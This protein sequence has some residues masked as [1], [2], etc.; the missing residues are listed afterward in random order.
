MRFPPFAG[1]RAFTLIELLVVIAII[2]VLISLLLPAVQQAREAARRTQ[3]RNNLK[4]I[5]LAMHNHNDTYRIFPMGANPQLYSPL[6]AVL[7]FMD[8]AN[9]QNLYD[10]DKSYDDAD[11]QA[12]LASSLSIYLCPTMV[13]PREV[14]LVSC[15]EIGGP[16]SYGCSMGTTEGSF[17]GPG[18]I[19]DGLFSGYN[20]L[21]TPIAYRFRDIID[22][23]SNTLMCGEF[24]YQ[25]QDLTWTTT[26][27][28]PPPTC[29]DDPAM[30]GQPRWGSH[31]WG[32]GYPY[33]SLGC[34]AGD[35][36]V[37]LAV[38]QTTWRSDHA[39]GA[40]F[41]LADGHVLFVSESVDAD[42]LDHLATR[43]GREVIGEF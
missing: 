25:L 43:A 11:N 31:R 10:F 28:F 21:V 34:T 15:G 39:G 42:L 2:A 8:Q 5:G 4:Q 33:G 3:C 27:G 20:G 35:F 24:N 26:P 29:P 38:N 9:L 1:R 6:V 32:V 36:N 18:S 37:N 30:E 14:P 40:H 13:L 41:L 16:T 23:T 7:P 19:T 12:A 17:G 22:G